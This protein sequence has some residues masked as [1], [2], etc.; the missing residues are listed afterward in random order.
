MNHIRATT[1]FLAAAVLVSIAAAPTTPSQDPKNLKGIVRVDGSS[2]VYLIAEAVAE[3]FS[4]VA[5]GVNVTVGM[6]GTGGGFKRFGNGE[7]DIS[8]ASR[9]IKKTEIEACKSH[10]IEFIELPVAFDGLTIV[11]NKENTWAKQLSIAQ[12]KKIFAS[13]GAAKTWKDVDASWPDEAIKIYSPGTDSGTFDYFKEVT[14]GKEGK[15]RS[16][17]SVSEDDNVIVRAVEGDKNAIGFF[18]YAYFVEN[19]SKLNAVK[20]VNPKTG[21]AVGP[22]PATIE[23]ASYAPF[24]RPLF[25]Y[26]NKASL[27][28]PAVAA[29]AAFALENGAKL[30]TEVGYVKLP[31]VMYDR[32]KAN[33]AATKLGTQMLDDNGME[34]MGVLAD[35]YK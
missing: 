5:P 32:A 29:Y 9:G 16:D 18:G 15:I 13:S 24:S 19:Q 2:T 14:V 30:A 8:N 20:V 11:T 25:I 21:A 17:I 1:L 28:K 31:S 35:I 3:E 12:I 23:D 33:L 34:R 6:S 27:A 26:V 7:T 10:K 4:K 22:S